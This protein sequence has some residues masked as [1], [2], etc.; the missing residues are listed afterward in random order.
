MNWEPLHDR[1]LVERMPR[2]TKKGVLYIPD[3]TQQDSALCKVL[4]VGPGVWRDGYFCK[5]AVKP[6]DTVLVP[7]AGNKFP[8][9]EAGQQILIQEG[10]VGAIVA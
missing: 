2:E 3:V 9:W 7:G 5:T 10:D 4:K 8:D 1:L 6:G